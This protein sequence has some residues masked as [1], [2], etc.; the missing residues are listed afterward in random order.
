MSWTIDFYSSTLYLNLRAE[1]SR[2]P[3]WKSFFF[4]GGGEVLATSNIRL[5][6]SQVN[7]LADNTLS[8]HAT[9]VVE[10]PQNASV[11]SL[12][13][14]PNASGR[15]MRLLGPPQI[16]YGE[17]NLVGGSLGHGYT[18]GLSTELISQT[19]GVP[20]GARS[21]KL[22]FDIRSSKIPG[23]Q[24][25]RVRFLDGDGNENV[26]ARGLSL[27]DGLGPYT[28]AKSR[29]T[30]NVHTSPSIKVPAS[31]KFL[32]IRGVPFYRYQVI[33]NVVP[34][35]VW[36]IGDVLTSLEQ[37]LVSAEGKPLVVV[38]TTA[39]PVSDD[40]RAL[41]PNNL[42]LELAK[43]GINV[44]F[45]PFGKLRDFPSL[46]HENI[47]QTDRS[48]FQRV[49]LKLISMRGGENNIYCCTSFSSVSAVTTMDLMQHHGWHTVYEVRDDMEEF[50]RVG[51]SKWYSPM[52]E[53]RVVERA[54]MVM[55]VS[56]VLA[57]KLQS[58]VP[59]SNRTIHVLPN[60]A[61]LR[62]VHEGQPLRNSKTWNER[63]YKV[64]YVGHLTESWFD[65]ARLLRA[66]QNMPDVQ[67]E[68]IG[69]GMPKSIVLPSNATYFGP[70]S[71]SEL[72]QFVKE[73]RVGLIPFQSSPLSRGVDPNKLF[74]YAAW[75]LRTVSA[76]MGSVFDAPSTYVYESDHEFQ[77]AIVH[78]LLTEMT[79]HE[80]KVLDDFS[81]QNTWSNRADQILSVLEG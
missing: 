75:G 72:L 5:R 30:S 16:T 61:P 37:F 13:T 44:V 47:F 46:P 25:L 52:L 36:E 20:V 4:D 45:F 28:L 29:E 65:W 32:E 19:F 80:M 54:D 23:K 64:G 22:N 55:S 79:E 68:I 35:P 69:H 60:A 2:R 56:P 18:R 81:A 43:R 49:L 71:H 12:S 59:S 17:T 8:R 77:G 15:E 74:E 14:K 26:P 27:G 7:D 10:S 6:Q 31:A 33:H 34:E 21:L 48:D 50:N 42:S 62:T 1:I 40:S 39:P 53:R 67:F 3:H 63:P 11:M 70:K 73:W 38:D 78:A 57:D 58:L 24:A 9:I 41:R 76:P 66:V 51:Y